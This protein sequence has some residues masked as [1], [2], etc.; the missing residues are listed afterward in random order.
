MEKQITCP[1]CGK[2]GIPDYHKE[3]VTCDCCGTD[4]SI[5]RMLN[6]SYKNSSPSTSKWWKVVACI[7]SIVAVLA[8][9]LNFIPKTDSK[10]LELETSIK[11][12]EKTIVQLK[13]AIDKHVQEI[14]SLK[15]IKGIVSNHSATSNMVSETGTIT[16]TVVRFDSPCKISK[17]LFGSE[18]RY[19][20]IQRLIGH[21]VLRPG[22]IL[23][24]KK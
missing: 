22:E 19:K 11:E 10:N 5:Y 1:V 18:R 2:V 17:K 23:K 3:D 9:L 8:I 7:A 6:E 16:Y 14:D 15:A 13:D 21:R 12:Q 20:E 24:I 4:L